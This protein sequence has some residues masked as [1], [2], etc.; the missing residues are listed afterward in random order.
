MDA[1]IHPVEGHLGGIRTAIALSVLCI[2]LTGC[3]RQQDKSA[4]AASNTQSLA[5]A[6][7]ELSR[8]KEQAISDL[9]RQLNAQFGSGKVKVSELTLIRTDVNRYEGRAEVATGGAKAFVPLKVVA[10]GSTALVDVDASRL[11]MLLDS[12]K[13]NQISS[14]V[15]QYSST[16][17]KQPY[18]S[19]LPVYALRK[20]YGFATRLQVETPIR[21]TEGFYFGEGCAP[22][23]CGADA[24]AWQISEDGKSSD[25]V[26]LKWEKANEVMEAHATYYVFGSS[27]EDLSGPLKKWA[28]ENG[29]SNMNSVHITGD[30]L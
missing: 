24:A 30:T 1:L 19:F 13:T 12:S 17:L 25:V 23:A 6:A 2:L 22:H 16:V 21:R 27:P 29:M 8:A 28:V 5:S 11:A 20:N 18:V 4:P 3:D 9:Q 14:I 10:D 7:G 26:V 15:G